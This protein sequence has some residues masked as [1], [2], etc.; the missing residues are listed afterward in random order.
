M[1]FTASPHRLLA[2]ISQGQPVVPVWVGL[3]P[4]RGARS[5]AL[6][7]PASRSSLLVRIVHAGG[8]SVTSD[9][10]E[11]PRAQPDRADHEH[12]YTCSRRSS[13]PRTHTPRSTPQQGHSSSG[14]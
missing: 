8:R 11:D 2:A 9:S 13:A 5:A 14:G 6:T 12:L 1:A 3:S 10:D 4:A 7:D